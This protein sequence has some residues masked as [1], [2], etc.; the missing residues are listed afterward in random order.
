MERWGKNKVDRERRR[1]KNDE[2]TGKVTADGPEPTAEKAATKTSKP[3]A[4]K[5]AVKPKQAGGAA[6]AEKDQPSKGAKKALRNAVKTKVKQECTLIAGALVNKVK[7]GD[8]RCA[9]LVLSM[10][11]PKKRGKKNQHGGM[12]EGEQMASEPE[13]DGTIEQ[14]M[15]L[16]PHVD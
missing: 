16:A 11:E 9:D 10:V 1:K 6:G 2:A 15:R 3:K 5:T 4:G 8:K 13:W 14:L 7:T 12:N